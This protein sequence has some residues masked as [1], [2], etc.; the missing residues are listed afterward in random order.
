MAE[1]A[2]YLATLSLAGLHV[3]L[4]TLAVYYTRRALRRKGHHRGR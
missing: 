1:L 3:T 2:G 4:L